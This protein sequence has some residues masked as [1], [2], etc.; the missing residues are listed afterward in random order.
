MNRTKLFQTLLLGGILA[1][2]TGCDSSYHSY[3]GHSGFKFEP[4]SIDSFVLKYYGTKR[5]SAEDV[6]IMWHH[7]AREICRGSGYQHI[8]TDI[9]SVQGRLPQGNE[10]LPQSAIRHT[11]E[12]EITCL[13]P[14]I[15]LKRQQGRL[16]SDHLPADNLISGRTSD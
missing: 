5:N 4:L 12:G 3:N 11:L 13:A 1:V 16:L 10:L 6:E 14:N 2:I 15:A 8:Y 9:D 7:A